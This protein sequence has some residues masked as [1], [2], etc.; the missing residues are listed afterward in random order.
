[1][2]RD[3][4]LRVARPTADLEK[5][6]EMY[7]NGL[8]LEDLGSFRST[9]GSPGVMLG[10]PGTGYHLEFTCERDSPPPAMPDRES[11]PL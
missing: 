10:N 4:R 8:G 1:M 11:W 2:P 6:T 9:R 3:A 5:V 7:R